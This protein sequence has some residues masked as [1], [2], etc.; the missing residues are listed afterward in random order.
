M[1]S[2]HFRINLLPRSSETEM[3]MIII[4]LTSTVNMAKS[5]YVHRVS[6]K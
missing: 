4:Q 6:K 5:V 2:W 1:I 3:V